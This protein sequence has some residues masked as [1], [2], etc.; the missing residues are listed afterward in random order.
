VP[1]APPFTDLRTFEE[2]PNE[3][4]SV[5]SY[6]KTTEMPQNP[7]PLRLHPPKRAEGDNHIF[8]YIELQEADNYLRWFPRYDN[9]VSAK[10]YRE[11]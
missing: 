6:V 11:L 8:K 5:R 3:S 9:E 10:K 2:T 4:Q 1:A 7:P